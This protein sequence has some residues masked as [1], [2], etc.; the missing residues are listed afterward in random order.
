MY[1]SRNDPFIGG[2]DMLQE[3][4]GQDAIFQLAALPP[5]QKEKLRRILAN[6]GN[7]IL[8]DCEFYF[9]CK[10][11]LASSGETDTCF[12]PALALSTRPGRQGLLRKPIR[13]LVQ[14]ANSKDLV[15]TLPVF[16][17]IVLTALS[18][19][20]DEPFI[21]GIAENAVELRKLIAQED[22]RKKLRPSERKHIKK[23]NNA[24]K[25]VKSVE[26]VSRSFLKKKLQ[27]SERD[28]RYFEILQNLSKQLID[29]FPHID[30]YVAGTDIIDGHDL[31]PD[32]KVKSHQI[33]P[34]RIHEST[35]G[36]VTPAVN[37]WLHQPSEGW[38][39]DWQNSHEAV[40]VL[41]PRIPPAASRENWGDN[42]RD[43]NIVLS[44]LGKIGPDH[45]ILK[46]LTQSELLKSF[47]FA[48]HP[49]ESSQLTFGDLG[50]DLDTGIWRR[51]VPARSDSYC[52]GPNLTPMHERTEDWLDLEIPELLKSNLR[53]LVRLGLIYKD[54]CFSAFCTSCGL[55]AGKVIEK[56]KKAISDEY[57]MPCMGLDQFREQMPLFATAMNW[58]LSEVYWCTSRPNHKSPINDHYE[59]GD[60]VDLSKKYHQLVDWFF[61][62]GC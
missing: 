59:V 23:Y 11:G 37:A 8:E 46:F 26:R 25:D 19:S 53:E 48:I 5:D 20:G 41:D 52:R 28:S 44:R 34:Q 15:D 60:S 54:F 58:S 36:N 14:V 17:I 9:R 21:R 35:F 56:Q 47:V 55:D 6:L 32:F 3:L 40:T 1:D 51:W 16:L 39:E 30:A 29:L 62:G 49:L 43:Q 61:Q 33:I 13:T 12:F 31:D 57:Y 50:F 7:P 38:D 10:Y 24:M 42:F 45:D 2:F 4:Q 18:E 27:I 22:E